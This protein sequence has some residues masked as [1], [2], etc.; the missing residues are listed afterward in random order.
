MPLY[1]EITFFVCFM[2]ALQIADEKCKQHNDIFHIFKKLHLW[3]CIS[4]S[5]TALVVP[6]AK[7]YY[8]H[9]YVACILHIHSHS[10][11]VSQ[12]NYVINKIKAMCCMRKWIKEQQFAAIENNWEATT[13]LHLSISSICR[14]LYGH[15]QR[16]HSNWSNKL[17]P[18][19][20]KFFTPFFHPKVKQ[21]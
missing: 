21:D 12:S 18:M 10:I 16:L 20:I 19:E 6:S 17:H 15:R 8:R 7:I 1:A 2:C 5:S 11:Y 13:I 3:L 4:S 14:A 9:S